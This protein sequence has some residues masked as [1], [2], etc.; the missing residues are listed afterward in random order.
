M[1]EYR[2]VSPSE[3]D[4][5]ERI[6]M[7]AFH[8][9]NGPWDE[10][11]V[12]RASPGERY[13]LFED[14]ELRSISRQY[15]FDARFRGEW[16][17]L[18]GLGTVATP[19]EHRHSGYARRM[20][21][22]VVGTY[23]AESIPLVALWPFETAF[24]RQ[25]GWTTANR[26]STYEC[27]PDALVGIGD[28]EG[29][30]RPVE[31]EDWRSLQTVHLTAGEGETLSL[32]RSETWWRRRIFTEWGDRRRHV[33][34][35]DRDGTPAGYVVHSLDDDHLQVAYMAGIDHEAYRELLGFLGDHRA[36][37]DRITFERA[38][39][40]ELFALVTEPNAI[41]CTVEPG[42]MVRVTDV[43]MALET[44]PYPDD[45]E[46]TV[47][48]AVDDPLGSNN[49]ETVRLRVE[50][51]IGE[52]I[53]NP[54][55][56]PDARLDIGT[57]SGLVV[58]SHDAATAVRRGGVTVESPDVRGRLDRLFPPEKVFLREFF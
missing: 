26:V 13:G 21:G 24:Y 6:R 48:L 7:Y 23:A 35:Y 33:Y 2:R 25:F 37:T 46:G 14:D 11:D 32:R 44:V 36:Q 55:G 47:T 30:F 18:G 19:P 16:I 40:S 15:T 38:E 3:A 42:P 34:R 57:L 10:G 53:R 28:D 1:V 20:L 27:D 9:D 54:D 8:P 51:G 43:E 4:K 5:Y 41:E 58:G 17:T 22:D 31:P 50:D 52:T 39:E 49:D 56:D 12:D 45:V 29:T